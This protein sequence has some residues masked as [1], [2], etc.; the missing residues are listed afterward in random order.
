MRHI[1]NRVVFP[2]FFRNP[3]GRY[4]RHYNQK[5]LLNLCVFRSADGVVILDTP[6]NR[7]VYDG[8]I[9]ELEHMIHHQEP[10]CGLCGDKNGDKKIDVKTSQQCAATTVQQAA[11][12]YRIQKSCSSPSRRQV[13]LK[14]RQQVCQAQL[15]QQQLESKASVSKTIRSQLKMCGRHMH[16]IVQQD[17]RTCI[18]QIPVLECSSGCSSKTL[19]SKLVPYTCL[20]MG[21]KRIVKVYEEK[22]RRGEILPELRSMNKSFSANVEVPVS[23]SHPAL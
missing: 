20:P 4:K 18:S 2:I 23:C 19:V 11:L 22:V 3:S 7:I 14:H 6:E 16:S 8:K 15:K 21:N 1:A 12:S 17:N 9:V 13:Q 5:N 10:E